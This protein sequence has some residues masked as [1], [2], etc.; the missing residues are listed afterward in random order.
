VSLQGGVIVDLGTTEIHTQI[1]KLLEVNELQTDDELQS[2]LV[3]RIE[4]LK[5]LF[6]SE[7]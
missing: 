5:A 4:A 6:S 2:F 1:E 7:T 3:D